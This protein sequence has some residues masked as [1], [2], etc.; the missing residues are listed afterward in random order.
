MAT[1]PQHSGMEEKIN[2]ISKETQEMH[3]ALIG[4]D[5]SSGLVK[6]VA[7]IDSKLDLFIA[8]QKA[9]QE[10]EEQKRKEKSRVIKGLAAIG[11]TVAMLLTSLAAWFRGS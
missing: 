7:D 4:S 2:H 8:G 1:C 5:M 3:S 10:L 6:K 11:A 9:Q